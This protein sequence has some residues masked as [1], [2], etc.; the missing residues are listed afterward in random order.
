MV[1]LWTVCTYVL[2][3][4]MPTYSVRC[5]CNRPASRPA[6]SAADDHVLL[7]DR[8]RLA[9]V[10]GRRVFLSGSALAIFVLAWPM[11]AWINHA[12]GFTSLIVFQAVFGVLIATCG[13]DPRG[14]RR[15]VPDQG[16]VD[17]VVRRVQLRGHDLRLRAVPDHV[18]HRP[19]RGNMAPAF[20]VT[21]AAAVSFVGTRFVK[22]AKRGA[23]VNR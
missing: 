1:I 18:A 3:F 21:L 17:R 10:W 23:S 20:Y 22:D 19:H 11:F 8:R 2:L 15:T 5:T 9:D 6:W 12:P 16:A 4:Y 13:A 7:A 14:V